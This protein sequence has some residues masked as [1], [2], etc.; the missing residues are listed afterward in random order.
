MKESILGAEMVAHKR[1]AP[2]PYPA[3]SLAVMCSNIISN[4]G[5]LVMITIALF[6]TQL[7]MEVKL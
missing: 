1:R 3:T 7:W 2:T 5:K 4:F 6:I